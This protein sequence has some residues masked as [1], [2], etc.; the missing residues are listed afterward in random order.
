M[1]LYCAS[2]HTI[3]CLSESLH[4][5][6]QSVAPGLRSIIFELG[7][8]R[9]SFLTPNNRSAHEPR[10]ADYAGAT[11]AANDALISTSFYPW[12]DEN[13]RLRTF[14]PEYNQNQPGSPEKGCKVMVDVLRGE[15][16]ARGRPFPTVLQLGSDCNGTVKQIC[17][18]AIQRIEEWKDI[19]ASTD[20]A[21]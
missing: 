17:E 9:T 10:I 21:T 14:I 8:F 20:I 13:N 15:G 11:A 12:S 3:R 18:Q 19:G 5:E 1:G 4:E 2:K 7:Y 16:L 6:L